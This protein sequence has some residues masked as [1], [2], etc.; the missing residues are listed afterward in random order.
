MLNLTR[1]DVGH[2][3][4]DREKLWE[5]CTAKGMKAAC[6]ICV[7]VSCDYVYAFTTSSWSPTATHLIVQAL[8][9]C[10]T[11][12]FHQLV[13]SLAR[14]TT[15]ESNGAQ[16]GGWRSLSRPQGRSADLGLYRGLQG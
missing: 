7:I 10:S 15:W 11:V 13:Y 14:W 5:R 4:I 16:G 2:G 6:W 1:Q 8:Y 9:V 3:G 12:M